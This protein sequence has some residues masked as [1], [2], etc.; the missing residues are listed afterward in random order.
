MR[1]WIDSVSAYRHLLHGSFSRF[2]LLSR[3]GPVLCPPLPLPPS[4]PTRPGIRRI[5][6]VLRINMCCFGGDVRILSPTALGLILFLEWVEFPIFQQGTL[7]RRSVY[8]GYITAAVRERPY[9]EEFHQTSNITCPYSSPRIIRIFNAILYLHAI[10]LSH[11]RT[12]Y[13]Q[14]CQGS[15]RQ[16]RTLKLHA[17]LSNSSYPSIWF[18]ISSKYCSI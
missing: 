4:E 5:L 18:A 12:R 9:L 13:S 2:C 15:G 7:P 8:I 16:S 17:S 3:S 6:G 14:D 1:T 11:E 10:V